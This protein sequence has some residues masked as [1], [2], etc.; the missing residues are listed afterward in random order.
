VRNV[1]SIPVVTKTY[2]T[3]VLGASTKNLAPTEMLSDENE[4][5]TTPQGGS[6][7]LFV[8]LPVAGASL[9]SAVYFYLKKR[10]EGEI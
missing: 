7:Y 8:V 10:R 9:L 6:S 5:E 2:P 3:A 1:T 4:E